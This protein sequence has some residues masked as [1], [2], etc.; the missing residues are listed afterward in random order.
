MTT[1]SAAILVGGR[2]RRLGG[3]PKPWLDVG[4]TT[5]LG[6]QQ[7]VF[8]ALGVVPRLIAPSGTDLPPSGLDV[9]ADRVA[10]G[11]A[12]GALF[13]AL[14]AA[15]TDV[16]VVVA[17]DMPFLT[18]A[19]ALALLDRIGTHDAAVPHTAAAGWHPLAA[20]YARRS[21]RRLHDA[22]ASGERRVVAAVS[23]LDVAALD[24]AALAP[25]DPDGTLLCNVNTPDDYAHARRIGGL[26][27]SRQ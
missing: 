4:G 11:G 20:A 6:R 1:W 23:T 9:V 16:V 2:S 5:I 21:A 19:F 13:T 25:L 8:A 24:D 12:L 7:A 22:L 26:T 15:T 27:P 3:R 18:A 17:G 14:D 10:D